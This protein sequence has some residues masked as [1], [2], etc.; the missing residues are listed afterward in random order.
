MYALNR[1]T[2]RNLV[3]A[4]AQRLGI[5]MRHL[6]HMYQ[7]GDYSALMPAPAPWYRK[8]RV[9]GLVAAVVIVLAIIV[10]ASIL[11]FGG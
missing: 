2:R 10:S 3:R 9:W 7:N 4:Q 1:K 11:H 6:W 5:P 8:P